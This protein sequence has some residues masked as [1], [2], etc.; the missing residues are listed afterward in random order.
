MEDYELCDSL[1]V[2]IPILRPLRNDLRKVLNQKKSL[3]HKLATNSLPCD[4]C[5]FRHGAFSS[6]SGEWALLLSR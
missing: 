6:D 3:E 1:K 4:L 5:D 2:E